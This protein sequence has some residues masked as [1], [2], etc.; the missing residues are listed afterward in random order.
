MRY[1]NIVVS[2]G[3]GTPGA[4]GGPGR[5]PSGPGGGTSVN[6]QSVTH[7]T[8]MLR[9]HQRSNIIR[10]RN[11]VSA[12]PF[13]FVPTPAANSSLS[14]NLAIKQNPTPAEIA[15]LT[16]KA[17]PA[18]VLGGSVPPWTS[19]FNG[20][21]DPGALD[22][23]FDITVVDGGVKQGWLKIYG[24]TQQQISQASNFN[25]NNIA[26]YAGFTNGL[27]LADVETPKQGCIANGVIWPCWGNWIG[28]E[29]SIEFNIK[30]GKDGI[31]G[32]TDQRNIIHNM[33][34]GTPLSSA[35]T[36]AL[37]HAFPGKSINVN[38]SPNII[39]N[40]P[41]Q[42]F[43]QSVDQY[44]NYVKSLSHNILGTPDTTGYQGV[45]MTAFADMINVTDGTVGGSSVQLAY[46]DLIGQ[47]SW[48]P[49]GGGV[50]QVKTALRGDIFTKTANGNVSITLPFGSLLA[51]TPSGQAAL[52]GSYFAHGDIL[53]FQGPW[54]VKSVRHVGKF[55]Q[56]TGES[57]VTIIDAFPGGVGG[58]TFVPF[59]QGGIGHA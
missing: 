12:S 9:G 25:N 13:A 3:T 11:V 53:T 44:E 28:N 2:A 47:P 50:M 17:V 29:L 57:W 30:A 7:Q 15:A 43:Y 5:S 54:I 52:L 4:G 10:G 55:R 46:V 48:S 49:L 37:T 27:P 26:I 22:I 1:Y 34:S 56:P 39:L 14:D 6:P 35:I 23:E 36:Q 21:N 18:S 41:D 59:G 33:P 20:Q 58:T 45:T 8:T 40:Y 32:P 51:Q 16:G 42:G 31:G 24:I 38:I 19:V